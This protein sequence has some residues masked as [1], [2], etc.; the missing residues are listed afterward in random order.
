[1]ELYTHVIDWPEFRDLQR[2]FFKAHV[3]DLEL[4]S[5]HAIFGVILQLAR[6]HKLKYILSGANHSTEAIMPKAWV[7]RKSDRKNIEDIH[8][9]FGQRKVETFPYMSTLEHV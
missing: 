7:H 5:D 3:V 2:S 6:K 8:R 4:L 9:R 1:F